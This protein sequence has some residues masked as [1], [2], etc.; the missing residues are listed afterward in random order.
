M[1]SAVQRPNASYLAFREMCPDLA[2][3]LEGDACSKLAQSAW[4]QGFITDILAE[5]AVQKTQPLSDGDRTS[6]VVMFISKKMKGSDAPN[7][8]RELLSIMLNTN[9]KELVNLAATMSK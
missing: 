7:T 6:M 5:N 8:M 9:N 3:V 4:C 2:R 1:A